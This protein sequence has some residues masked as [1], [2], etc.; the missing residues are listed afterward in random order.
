MKLPAAVLP[1]LFLLIPA[2]GCTRSAAPPVARQDKMELQGFPPQGA[3]N[4]TAE[5]VYAYLT[6]S[7]DYRTFSLVPGEKGIRE[8]RSPHGALVR[9]RVNAIGLQAMKQGLRQ[10][11][12]GSIVVKENFNRDQELLALTVMMKVTNSFPGAGDWYWARFSTQDGE[13]ICGSIQSCLL[14]H[15]GVKGNDY[16]FTYQRK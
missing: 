10:L 9:T 12:H 8:G 2:A 7:N 5:Q 14:C 6:L 15:I 1:L 11:P 16:L 3:T 4:I 13:R